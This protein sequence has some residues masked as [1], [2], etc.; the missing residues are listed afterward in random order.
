MWDGEVGK[1]AELSRKC[2]GER[3]NWR[4]AVVWQ[5]WET[6]LPWME[7]HIP[8]WGWQRGGQWPGAHTA[9]AQSHDCPGSE[10]WQDI[11]DGKW[12]IFWIGP[13]R[14]MVR[15]AARG[16]LF[17]V[18]DFWQG[19]GMGEDRTQLSLGGWPLGICPWPMS[20]WAT[21]IG[22]GVFF[23]LFLFSFPKDAQITALK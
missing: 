5:V 3:W 2:G 9:S 20:I 13:P 21:R 17:T 23:F 10:Q 19:W 12:F 8:E 16:Q 22:F 6:R 14:K 15:A 4:C 11:Q 1:M 7:E 18:N